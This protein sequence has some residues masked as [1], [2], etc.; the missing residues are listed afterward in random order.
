MHLEIKIRHQHNSQ[1]S[2]VYSPRLSRR[3]RHRLSSV[4]IFI[5]QPLFTEASQEH[6]DSRPRTFD[7]LPTP[8]TD[9]WVGV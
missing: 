6:T 3:A 9:D 1:N 4:L 7:I 8:S 2:L 5:S